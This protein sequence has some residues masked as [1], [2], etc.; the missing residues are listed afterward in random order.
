MCGIA[1]FMDARGA[2]TGERLA[3]MSLAMARTLRHRGPD[4]SGVWVDPAAG[5][6]LAHRRLAI[7]DLSP[8]GRRE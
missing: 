6:S 7:V 8:A 3:S 2:L 1:G 5:V 4:D